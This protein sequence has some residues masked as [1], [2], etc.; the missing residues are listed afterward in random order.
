MDIRQFCS[1][2]VKHYTTSAKDIY[3]CSSQLRRRR[4]HGMVAGIHGAKMALSS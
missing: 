2:H 3:I 4:V 1:T